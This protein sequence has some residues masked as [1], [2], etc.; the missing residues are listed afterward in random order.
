L[1]RSKKLTRLVTVGNEPDNDVSVTE[2]TFDGTA[3]EGAMSVFGAVHRFRL[4]LPGRH[5]VD[6]AMLAIGVASVLNLDLPPLIASL[7]TVEPTSRRFARYLI[8]T[9]QGV[10]ELI[11]DSFNAAPNSVAALLDTLAE[12]A[13]NRKVLVFGDMLEL[14]SESRRYHAEL[15]PIIRRAGVDLLI[16]VGTLAALVAEGADATMHYADAQAAAA[17]VASLLRP[18]DLVAVKASRRIGLDRV[19]AAIQAMGDSKHAVS[20]RIEDET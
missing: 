14:G 16:T 13:A 15:A 8:V 3:T 2:A 6:N 7:A 12:R 9:T 4:S 11:D 17:A 1:I 20:W 10:L 5:F 18:G 19:V